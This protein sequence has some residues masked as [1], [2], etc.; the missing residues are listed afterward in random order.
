MDQAIEIEGIDGSFT[1]TPIKGAVDIEELVAT[2][3]QGPCSDGNNNSLNMSCYETENQ[4]P[5][6]DRFTCGICNYSTKYKSNLKRH[7]KIHSEKN[8]PPLVTTKPP[9]GAAKIKREYEYVCSICMYATAQIS[10]GTRERTCIMKR[11]RN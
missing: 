9:K 4:D 7:S 2:P 8:E 6:A 3:I 10:N 5:D 11:R 1:S